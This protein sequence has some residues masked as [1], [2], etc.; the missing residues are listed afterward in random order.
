VAET[1]DASE[2]IQATDPKTPIWDDAAF[3]QRVQIAAARLGKRLPEICAEA[4]VAR[5]YLMKP[6]RSGRNI[7]LVLRIARVLGVP[8]A[9]L[10]G[11]NGEHLIGAEAKTT[12][13]ANSPPLDAGEL[14]RLRIVASVAAQLRV[15]L[16]NVSLPGVDGLEIIR[17][18]IDMI[19]RPR[20]RAAKNGATKHPKG[21]QGGH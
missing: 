17:G 4:G 21:E 8:Y 14:E 13:T 3:C 9:D 20:H 12:P 1:S 10:I 16:D 6:A 18:V 19:Q 2:A 15:A 11:H 7:D 5:D